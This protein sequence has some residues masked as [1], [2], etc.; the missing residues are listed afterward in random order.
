[1]KKQKKNSRDLGLKRGGG[2]VARR[3]CACQKSQ[4]VSALAEIVI[5]EE[6]VC[7]KKEKLFT[8]HY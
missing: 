3:R 8:Y 4:K 2:G 5:G 7:L 1:L 6:F